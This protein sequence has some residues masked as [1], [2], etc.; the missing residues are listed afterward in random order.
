[1]HP[2]GMVPTSKILGQYLEIIGGGAADW[3]KPG[4]SA[5]VD[6]GTLAN[7]GD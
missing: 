5:N 3:R 6:W 2:Y 7:I 4:S 1:M